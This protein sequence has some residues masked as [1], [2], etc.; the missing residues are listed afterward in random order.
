[1]NERIRRRI[2]Q[3][4]IALPDE[5]ILEIKKITRGCISVSSWVRMAIVKEL[6]REGK[7]GSM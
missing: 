7:R 2:R 5:M 1:M 3:Q 4:S 6:E